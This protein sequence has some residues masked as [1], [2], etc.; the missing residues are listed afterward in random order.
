[1]FSIHCVRVRLNTNRDI[2]VGRK[3]GLI[4]L[5]LGDLQDVMVSTTSTL[6]SRNIALVDINRSTSYEG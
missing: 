1:M 6:V 5:C 3:R 2:W 4:G